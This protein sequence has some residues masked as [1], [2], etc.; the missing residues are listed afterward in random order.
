[1]HWGVDTNLLGLSAADFKLFM[2][3][4]KMQGIYIS[5]NSQEMKLQRS[6]SLLF[7]AHPSPLPPLDWTC[8]L[9]LVVIIII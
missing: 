5:Y 8:L 7:I 4:I 3:N 6:P 2:H 1:M 9:Q